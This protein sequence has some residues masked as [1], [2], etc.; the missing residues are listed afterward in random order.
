MV[1]QKSWEEFRETGLFLFVNHFLHM[2]GWAIVIEYDDEK[3]VKDVYPARVKFR[4]F[5]EES[6]NRAFKRLSKY[7]A[8]HG[9][10]LLDECDD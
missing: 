7:M 2:F 4:G 5:S 1:T 3:N 10:E 6:E 9:N 8:E